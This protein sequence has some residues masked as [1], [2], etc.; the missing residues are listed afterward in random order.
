[1]ANLIETLRE[2]NRR[3][4]KLHPQQITTAVVFAAENGMYQVV[5]AGHTWTATASISQGLN[6]GDR[7]YVLQGRGITKII[8]LIGADENT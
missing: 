3:N 2:G 7:V 1:M 5:S 8:G 4:S 6:V